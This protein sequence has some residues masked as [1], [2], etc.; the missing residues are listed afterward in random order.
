MYHPCGFHHPRRTRCSL[1]PWDHNNPD[2]P[3]SLVDVLTHCGDDSES[4]CDLIWASSRCP[5]LSCP[6]SCS[7]L[8]HSL[9]SAYRLKDRLFFPL[10]KVKIFT[11]VL[12]V[13][14]VPGAHWW[15]EN[16]P[17]PLH[18]WR[19]FSCILFRDLGITNDYCIGASINIGSSANGKK[20]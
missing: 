10:T 13:C 20:P 11:E 17:Q 5:E 6:T 16:V 9:D 2:Q 18:Q 12:T 3:F 1:R 8:A 14:P 4:P 19:E 15:D 7:D